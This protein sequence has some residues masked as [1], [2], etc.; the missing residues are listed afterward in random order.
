VLPE[1]IQVEG[2]RLNGPTVGGFASIIELDALSDPA[3]N[4]PRPEAGKREAMVIDP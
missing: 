3:A 2:I 1:T 4:L